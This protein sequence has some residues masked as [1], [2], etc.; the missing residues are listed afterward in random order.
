ARNPFLITIHTAIRDIQRD[1]SS[2]VVMMAGSITMAADQHLRIAHAIADQ[3]SVTAAAVMDE[4]LG[5]TIRALEGVLALPPE[6]RRHVRY[7]GSQ[8]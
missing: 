3:D 2:R 6:D 5:V 1:V 8:T 4:H 7:L